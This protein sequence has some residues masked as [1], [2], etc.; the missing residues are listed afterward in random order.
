MFIGVRIVLY[1]S[2]FP[3]QGEKNYIECKSKF[4]L[5]YLVISTYLEVTR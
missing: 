1:A 2:P 5:S 4:R 3:P